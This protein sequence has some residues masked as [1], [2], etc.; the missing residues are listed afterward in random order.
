MNDLGDEIPLASPD[1]PVEQADTLTKRLL[2]ELSADDARDLARMA[3]TDFNAAIADRSTWEDRLAEDERQYFGILPEKTFP[4]LGCS[5][6]HVP[7]TMTGVETLKPR[8]IESVLGEDPPVLLK[9]TDAADETRQERAEAFLNWQIQTQMDLAPKVAESAHRYLLPGTVYA[10]T[11][12]RLKERRV[13]AIRTFPPETALDVILDAVLGD[14]VPT[15]TVPQTGGAFPSWR[16]TVRTPQHREREAVLTLHILPDEIQALIDR[17]EVVYEGPAVEFPAAEDIIEPTNA[18]SDP[19][20]FP[21]IMQRLWLDVSRLRQK[22]RQGRFYED[23]VE[24]LLRGET[25]GGDGSQRDAGDVRAIRAQVEGVEEFGASSQRGQEYAILECYYRY[26][27]DEDGLDEELVFWVCP[28]R[29]ELLLGWD[30]LDN[31]YATG[32]RPFRKACYFPIPGRSKG[33]SFPQIVQ[34]LQDEINT[35]HNQRVDNGTIRDTCSFFYPKNWTLSPQQ[36]R[37][38]PGDGIAVDDPQRIVFAQWNGSAAG[39]QNEEALLMQIFERLTGIND[40]SLGRQPNRVGATRTATGVSSLLSEAGLRFKT[41]MSGFQRFWRDIFADIL[42]LDQQYLPD[43]VEFRVT[44]KFPEVIRLASRADIAGRYDVRVVATSDS[45]NRQQMRDDA[46]AKLQMLLNPIVLQLGLVGKKGL[47]RG[48]RRWLQAYGESDPDLVL[49][50]MQDPIVRTPEQEHAMWTNGD[51]SAE[52]TM[53]EN[54]AQ[55]LDAHQALL[56][57]PA[58]QAML[59]PEALKA[60][61]AHVAKTVQLAQMQAAIQS[62]Q[63]KGA[64]PQGAPVVGEQAAN[65]QIG[66][67]QG[68]NGAGDP[69]QMGPG[70]GMPQPGGMRRG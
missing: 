15:K 8:L 34:A 56:A 48:V 70:A 23:A 51:Y 33:L 55:H 24:L 65:A 28:E 60:A 62:M 36:E 25:P 18:G 45:M 47:Y 7:I 40:L 52:P 5:N 35:I 9:G 63:Q 43:G 2:P 12:W 19:Q 57:N 13:Q 6:L 46:T 68:L 22:V 67:Q 42:A 64:G 66:R 32:Q 50:V 29:G 59:S 39:L 38:R 69:A 10:K 53:A 14:D 17:I 4:W 16:I 58:A 31:L 27:L 20:Q 61:Q 3:V 54:L 30:Y 26:D 1:K 11:W 41:A 37:V 49:E 44:G 21:W